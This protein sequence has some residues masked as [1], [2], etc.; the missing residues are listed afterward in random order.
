M[1]NLHGCNWV[2]VGYNTDRTSIPSM[3]HNWLMIIEPLLIVFWQET[4]NTFLHVLLARLHSCSC[5]GVSLM[6]SGKNRRSLFSHRAAVGFLLDVQ[7]CRGTFVALLTLEMW[8]IEAC[9]GLVLLYPRVAH[10]QPFSLFIIF[11][12]TLT[13]QSS[14]GNV[15]SPA[16]KGTDPS[17]DDLT[18][19]ISKLSFTPEAAEKIM[20][21]V[22]HKTIQSMA[23]NPPKSGED[24]EGQLRTNIVGLTPCPRAPTKHEDVL[25]PE[26]IG[27]LLSN[28][29]SP[30]IPLLASPAPP[31]QVVLLAPAT[32]AISHIRH[33]NIPIGHYIVSYN[34][35]L[36]VLPSEGTHGRLVGI[37][38]W[39]ENTSPLVI[40]ISGATFRSVS[41]VEWGWK[42]IED[43]IKY[44]YM[45]ESTLSS[46]TSDVSIRRGPAA[47]S[48]GIGARTAVAVL[49][50][51]PQ[52]PNKTS[53]SNG[54]NLISIRGNFKPSH[55]SSY[56][57]ILRGFRGMVVH[58]M[59]YIVAGDLTCFREVKVSGNIC[60]LRLYYKMLQTVWDCEHKTSMQLTECEAEEHNVHASHEIICKLVSVRWVGSGGGFG[61]DLSFSDGVDRGLNVICSVKLVDDAAL[62]LE[63][64]K[65]TSPRVGWEQHPVERGFNLLVEVLGM[66]GPVSSYDHDMKGPLGVTRYNMEITVWGKKLALGYM[67]QG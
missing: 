49:M 66:L 58:V 61:I 67:K 20:V 9:H 64:F 19:Q 15:C 35:M 54:I 44:I 29:P 59:G 8:F 24:K 1:K 46:F 33:V 3:P 26:D 51:S 65:E 28:N 25:I 7:W 63:G 12:G 47:T 37:I 32:P 30:T 55:W 21:A 11:H 23:P 5:V 18:V 57:I 22:H 38:A 14:L 56:Q 52:L 34:S 50:H 2:E 6:I 42:A 4:H 39:W 41:S 10:P 62:S 36:V 60:E 17:V 43:A 27:G 45:V 40:G 53:V 31:A 48:I 13:M 16:W